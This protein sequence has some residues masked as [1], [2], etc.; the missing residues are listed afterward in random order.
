MKQLRYRSSL[1]LTLG[2]LPLLAIFNGALG[3]N[4][5]LGLEAPERA[6][7]S[8]GTSQG[9]GG[10]GGA[11]NG[12]G[13]GE[14]GACEPQSVAAC[15][16]GPEG[17]DGVGMCRAG[18]KVCREDGAYGACEGEVLPSP[19]ACGATASDPNCNGFSQSDLIFGERFGDAGMQYAEG[20]AIDAQGNLILVG[21]FTG[22][23]DFGGGPLASAGS[24][25]VFVAKFT[26]EGKHL[27]SNRY[28][29]ANDQQGLAVAVD[30]DGN[31]IVTGK[32]DGSIDLGGETLASAGSKDVFL[33]KL[34]KD[35][36]H[37]WSKAFG[38]G[39]E[40]VGKAVAV[41]AQGNI[42]ICGSFQGSMSFGGGNLTS[43]GSYDVFLAAFDPSGTRRWDKRFG[44]TNAQ[45]CDAVGMDVDGNVVI[46]GRFAG[47]VGFGKALLTSGGGFDVYVAKFGSDGAIAWNQ[48]FGSSG[49]QIGKSLAIGPDGGVVIGGSFSGTVNFGG[50]EF[51]NPPP[52]YAS[53]FIAK[54]DAMGTHVFSKAFGDESVQNIESVAVDA[55]GDV[56]ATGSFNG[57]VDFGGGP[58]TAVGLGDM[59]LAK[60][61][62]KGEYKWAKR[63]G[64]DADQYGTAV[65]VSP[66]GTMVVAGYF[67]GK[68][69]MEG[70]FETQGAYDAMFA[71][72]E[73]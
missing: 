9:Q 45:E 59:Y 7:V 51:S 72:F 73:P 33:A 52:A 58:L 6:E 26:A 25:D 30:G 67:D 2:A 8:S 17:T 28:G 49:D 54:L 5:I 46:T 35:G 16:T 48:S 12:A 60:L 39:V 31:L 34:N 38:D 1:F 69:D 56:F 14:T 21:S 63:Y 18:Q 36:G 20:A 37:I 15:Y 43:G 62:P 68:L 13:G 55:C 32:F 44:D 61:G 24:N 65:A 71:R 64:D 11:G 19:L 57:N 66:L 47:Q 70:A 22:T 3:C 41:D 40:Q 29:N 50:G 10:S 23:V 42:A 53:I 4:A 27:W